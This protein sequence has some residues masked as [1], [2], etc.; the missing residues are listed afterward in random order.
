MYT[1][2]TCF[3]TTSEKIAR[4]ARK[5][6]DKEGAEGVTTR[7]VAGAVGIT[8]MALYRHYANRDA[9][10][11][12]LADAGFAELAARL[13]SLDLKGGF[14]R[15]LLKI[16]DVYLDFAFE[17]PQLYTLMFLSKREGARQFPRDFKARNSPT[18]NVPASV[19]VRAM[20][21]GFFQKDDPWEIVFETGAMQQGLILLYLGDRVSMSQDQFRAYC[22]RAFG[23]YLHGIRS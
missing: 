11:N 19:I 17:S 4:A 22:H 18:A 9:L 20:D 3:M 16:L 14:D 10:L 6:L 12:A 5:L 23:R 15:Q 21:A 8:A 7:R 2:Y 1:A 13:T